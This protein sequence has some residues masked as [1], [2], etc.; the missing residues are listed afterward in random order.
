[1]SE[2]ICAFCG[3]SFVGKGN[4]KFCHS[5]HEI[6]CD[7]CGEFFT[8]NQRKLRENVRVC[9]PCLKIRHSKRMKELTSSGKVG[10]ANQRNQEAA[11]SA[12]RAK[13]GVDN[14]SQVPEIRKRAKETMVER[15]GAE[16]SFSSPELRDRISKTNLERYGAENPFASEQIKSSI[17]E[18]LLDLYGV[19]NVTL[20]PD[21]RAKQLETMNSRY[22]VNQ[23]LQHREFYETQRNTLLER[24]G[25]DNS[26]KLPEVR[27]KSRALRLAVPDN[28]FAA[29][30][31]E[32]AAASDSGK[33]SPQLL[34]DNLDYESASPV[35]KRIKALGLQELI[36]YGGDSNVNR[37]WLEKLQASL[38]VTFLREGAIFTDRRW[39]ADLYHEETRVAIDINPTISHSTQ[40]AHPIYSPKSTQYHRMRA[41]DAEANG[42]I[43]YQV[44]DWTPFEQCVS[45][46]RNLL[47]LNQ[48]RYDARK[49]SI[50]RPNIAEAR[51]FLTVNHLQGADAVGSIIFGLE[52]EGELIQL[53]TFSKARF[54]GALAQYELIRL[55]SKGTVRGG[56]S[57][58]FKAFRGAY[59]PESVQTY[60]SLD[61]G[62]GKVYE[63]L[64]FRY[65][66]L[67]AL[68]GLY[69]KPGTS[70]AYKVTTCA[71]KFG[72]EYKAAGLTQQQYM[73]SKGFFRINDAGNK[74]FIW[75]RER[76]E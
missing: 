59:S 58:L 6:S 20:N 55:A 57:R 63:T 64:G 76:G 53:M 12:V 45:Q 27:E 51:E 24:Y 33:I 44:Y 47:G 17:R 18:T 49:C 39:K 14:V 30:V 73:N 62:H 70:E 48:D 4:Q 5:S 50:V 9:S 72:A 16:S 60:S 54:R 1:M 56:A 65:H 19:E 35:Y 46:L 41:L 67:T 38:G 21:I 31:R 69:S 13:Y 52:H 43:L 2:R 37:E 26:A 71:K 75:E 22:G 8:P 28:D 7:D 42:W 10:F 61:T 11:K 15:Y 36:Q 68:N 74:I 32:L 25:L 66:G 3:D 34:M 29:L 40:Q 23:P